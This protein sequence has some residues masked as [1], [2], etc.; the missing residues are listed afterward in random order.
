MLI[1]LT[2]SSGVFLVKIINN[3][4]MHILMKQLFK[5]INSKLIQSRDQE[6]MNWVD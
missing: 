1:L 4:T 3:Q 5:H 2:G 6:S